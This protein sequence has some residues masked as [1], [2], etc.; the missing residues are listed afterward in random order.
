M[1][2]ITIRINGTG[3]ESFGGT[4]D[5]DTY[6]YFEDNDVDLEEYVEDIEF[7]NDNLDIPEQYNFGCNGIEEIDNLWHMNGAYLD[8]HHNEIEVIDSDENQIWKSPLTFEALKEK[9]VQ[10]ESDGDFDDIVNELPEKTAVMVGR[11]V[12]NGVIFEVEIEVYKD[13]DVT[14]LVIYL[15]EDDGQDVIKRMEYDGE[16]I[17]DESSSSDGKSQEYSWFIR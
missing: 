17:E 16:I 15:H 5:F 3:V 13:F 2:R 11:K 14:K 7:G 9:G 8:I 6:K 10:L 4:V 1:S 12:A